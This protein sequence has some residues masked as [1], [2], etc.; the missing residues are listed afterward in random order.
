MEAN[1]MKTSN[2][3]ERLKQI[4]EKYDLRQ[5]DILKRCER[6]CEK[7]GIKIQRN[8]LS[9]Y[10]SGKVEPSQKKLSVLALALN[11]TEPW[12]MGYDVEPDV[13]TLTLTP[14]ERQVILSYRIHE[15]MQ[16]AVDRLLQIEPEKK[17]QMPG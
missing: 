16:D 6:Y 4:M 5:S 3:A 9:Q 12:L 14:H 10:I 1:N 8:D 15:E 11:V 17:K 2:T 13:V 7:F